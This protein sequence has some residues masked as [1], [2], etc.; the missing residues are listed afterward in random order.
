[1]L[2]TQVSGTSQGLLPVVSGQLIRGRLALAVTE[3]HVIDCRFLVLGVITLGIAGKL[4]SRRLGV[5][6]A[7]TTAEEYL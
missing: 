1:M 6:I 2:L 7:R 3:Q 5:H 4:V